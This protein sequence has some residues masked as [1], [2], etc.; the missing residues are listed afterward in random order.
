MEL[1]KIRTRRT[2]SPT[3]PSQPLTSFGFSA[4][5]APSLTVRSTSIELNKRKNIIYYII[6]SH[7]GLSYNFY[8]QFNRSEEENKTIK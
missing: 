5:Y 7:K 6:I 3:I 1:K 2:N 4:P 8:S